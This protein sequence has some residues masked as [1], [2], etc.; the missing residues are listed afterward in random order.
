M[1]KIVY[2]IFLVISF[3]NIQAQIL[4]TVGSNI[5]IGTTDPKQTLTVDT[6]QANSNAGVPAKSETVQNGIMRLQ[7]NG[8]KWGEVMDFGMNVMPTYGWIQATNRTD[9][10]VNY[11]L[12]LNPNGGNVGIGTT[13]NALY[14]LDVKGALRATEVKI[15]SI[16]NF[17]DFVFEK[18]YK[19]P[20]LS[21]VN[22]FIQKN[23]HLQN[24]PSA[25]EVKDNGMSL[26][27][28]QVKL[29]QKVEE[30]T[31]YAIEQQ[32]KI[33]ELEKRLK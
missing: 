23:G 20:K 32:K 27:E 3:S 10:S 6:K 26:V 22:N 16:E 9:L 24:I 2:I 33:E 8:D 14:K 21:E 18:N 11:N 5:G 17:P 29:L 19:L 15:E 28:M 13:P 7:V 1:K 12:V 31:L 30:L 25:T 4:T